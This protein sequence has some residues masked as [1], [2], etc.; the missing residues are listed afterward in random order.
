MKLCQNCG[1]PLAE[2]ISTCPSCGSEV[3][4]G[5][6]FI[7]DYMIV[8]VL[9][10]GYAS[11]LCNAIRTRTGE[12]VMIRLF[13]PQSG[14]DEKVAER[15][16][17][18][19][20]ELKK[21]PAE[22]FVRHYAIRQAPDGLWYRVSEWI[23]GLNWGELLRSG[24][25]KDYRAAF[26]LFA[27]IASILQE[28]HDSG[29]IIPHLILDDI[30][31]IEDENGELDVKIDY[32]FS[33]FFD[34]KLDRPGP[35]LKHLLSCHP[36]I[37]NG[38]PLDLKSDI[39]S[40]G[41]I[42][43]ELL[44][45]DYKINDYLAEVDEL[46]LPQD[47]KVLFKT[48]LADDPALRPRSM[49]EVAETL[50]RVTDSEI[51]LALTPQIESEEVSVKAIRRIRESQRLLVLLVILLIV[52]VAATVFHLSVREKDHATVLEDYANQ[53]APS[54]AFILVDYWLRDGEAYAYRNRGE[55]TAFLVD[56][57]G[58]L[59]TNRHVACP[60]LQDATFRLIADQLKGSGRSPQFGYRLF[61]WFEGTKAFNRS[62][63]LIDSPDLADAYFLRSAYRTDGTPRLTIAGVA[64]PPVQ[65]RQLVTSPLRDDF[66]VL[67]IE[68]IPK[69]LEPLRLDER[70][71]P[72]KVPKLSPI[73]ALG[74]PLGSR[75]QEDRVNVS[76]ASGHV[77]R[78]FEN[79]I[80]ID[81]SIYGGNS[82]GPM[83]DLHGKVI[84]IV[85]GVA[86]DRA[87]GFLP[88]V[89]PLWDMGMVFPITKAVAFLRDLKVGRV[90]WNGVLDLS[91]EEKLKRVFDL[92]SQARW[93]EAMA[94]ADR[95]LESSFDPQLIMAAGMMHFCADDNEGAS[96]LFGNS[97]SMDPENS[98]ARLM[99]FTI[100]W[101]AGRASESPHREDLLS[102][103]WR[104]PTEFQGYLARVMDALVEEESALEAW[105]TESEKSWLHYIVGLIHAGRG[106]WLRSEPRLRE[107]LFTA[108][109]ESWEYFLA[110][111]QLEQVQRQRLSSFEMGAA[112]WAKYQGEI[113]AFRE[114][115]MRGQGE[116]REK[117]DKLIE[118]KTQLLASTISKDKREILEKVLETSPANG[119]ALVGLAFYSAVDEEWDKALK[120]ARRFLTRC[121]REN[122]MRLSAGLLE[123][124]ILHRMDK[125]EE[126]KAVLEAFY[127]RTQDRWYR[128]ISEGLL[129]KRTEEALRTE[130]GNRP[131]NL[132]TL[133][134]ALG[135]WAEGS[136]DKEKAIE[137]YRE[138]LESFM[139]TWLEFDFA[140]QR[141][142]RLRQTSG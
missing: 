11:F 52:G 77:R 106:E 34:P 114:S 9:H 59:L 92:A 141:I 136:E 15:L 84:G 142:E 45:A 67:K 94:I 128:A 86:V 37:T 49:K 126:A 124:E 23:D 109:P 133:Y 117:R 93:A 131:E 69:G 1:Q 100:D 33:R 130:A 102:L 26:N 79:L 91:V 138:A 32:K 140:K 7:D 10:E 73:I 56:S 42:F 135:F 58:Y 98:L 48:M 95:E 40:L 47:A 103:D 113:E 116:K 78:T 70:L 99:L 16:R 66:A 44:T 2:Q 30:I 104:S 119:Q 81:A 122:A 57:D 111:S 19:L 54:V 71:D 129:G 89:T 110:Y 22:S 62:A 3:G 38:R 132:V 24:R 108:D 41:K 74:F 139:D 27:R 18:E 14:V 101:S 97:L 83:I 17:R 125:K 29:H 60:W 53:Y 35:L 36:D 121:G 134:M 96:E 80:Q 13:T 107:A 90:K 31:V 39:W 72:L 82:G 50:S 25:L 123:A 21:L 46:P 68:E 64:K 12:T 105:D 61:L 137:H 87:Q 115:V 88:V 63:G 112:G 6:R 43:I 8:T 75:T 5:R 51:E 55:G 28:L 85:S 65:T 76:V 127:H 4:E 118:L 120:Y 20:A